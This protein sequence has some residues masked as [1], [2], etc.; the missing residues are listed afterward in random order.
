MKYTLTPM[1]ALSDGGSRYYLVCTTGIVNFDQGDTLAKSPLLQRC[2][3]E[4]S[5][6]HK[7]TNGPELFLIPQGTGLKAE[8][9]IMAYP[10]VKGGINFEL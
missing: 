5:T 8:F 3:S 9:T 7:T 10:Y 4:I 1:G 6:A 2:V